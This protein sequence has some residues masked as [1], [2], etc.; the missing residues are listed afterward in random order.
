[1]RKGQTGGLLMTNDEVN[2]SPSEV[3]FSAIARYS[4][5]LIGRAV[6][7]LDCC[8]LLFGW[9]FFPETKNALQTHDDTRSSILQDLKQYSHS[10]LCTSCGML[11]SGFQVELRQL[12]IQNS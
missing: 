6:V 4:G 8:G 7:R 10:Q 5:M 11:Y 1:M 2:T 3:D 12:P 9:T